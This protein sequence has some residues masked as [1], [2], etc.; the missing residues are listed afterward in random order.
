MKLKI[1]RVQLKKFNYREM[2]ESNWRVFSNEVS[3]LVIRGESIDE[4]WTTLCTDIKKIVEISFP[5]KQS[6]S[7]YKFVMSQGLIKSK[8]KKNKLLKQYKRGQIDKEVYVRYNR[9]YRKL[10]TKEQESSFYNKIRDSGRDSKKN[11][12]C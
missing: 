2:K 6:R 8:N 4:K 5:E 11:G 9:I 1:K 3:K 7:C 12:E 10:I